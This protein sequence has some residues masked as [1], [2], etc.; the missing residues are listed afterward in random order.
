VTM[1]RKLEETGTLGQGFARLLKMLSGIHTQG[2]IDALVIAKSI[3][4]CS[5]EMTH[6][7]L[8]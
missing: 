4:R 7:R 2:L 3:A 1:P 8:K 6:L 5:L